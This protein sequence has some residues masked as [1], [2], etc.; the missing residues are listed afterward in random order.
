MKYTRN[1]FLS[2]ATLIPFF[3]FADVGTRTNSS[4]KTTTSEIQE[5]APSRF[6]IGPDLYYQEH[7]VGH[8]G[9]DFGYEY[10]RPDF[11]YG[12]FD[13]NTTWGNFDSDKF[14]FG[15]EGKLGYNFA[16]VKGLDLIPYM[17]FGYYQLN[18][19]NGSKTSWQYPLLGFWLNYAF[20]NR[21]EFGINLKG[22]YTVNAKDSYNSFF[23]SRYTVS[24]KNHFQYTIE[25]PTTFYLNEKKNWDLRLVPYYTQKN[26]GAR[27][28]TWHIFNSYYTVNIPVR[29]LYQVGGRIEVGYHF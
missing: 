19:K 26:L 22:M 12:R 14:N 11:V 9:L 3:G 2:L 15:A 4:G 24:L 23:N 6:F 20:T 18:G 10:R 28:G 1:M 21:I 29:H 25:L 27:T 8:Y 17:G 13:L 7:S 16:P 5:A